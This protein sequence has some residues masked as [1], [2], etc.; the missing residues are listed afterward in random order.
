MKRRRV[1]GIY[2]KILSYTILIL[3][4]VIGV[5]AVF[6]ANQI[7]AI[8]E[9]MERQQL[10]NMISPLV[11]Q[12]EGKSGEEIAGIAEEFHAKNASAKFYVQAGNG[13]IIYK[14]EDAILPDSDNPSSGG[15]DVIWNTTLKGKFQAIEPLSNGT[16]IFMVSAS[17]GRAVYGEFIRRTIIV[18]LL[19]FIVGALCA[20]VFAYWFT[21]PI[22]NIARDTRRMSD[23]EFVPPPVARG[24]EIGQ[25]AKDVYQMY[26]DLKTEIE[27]EREMEENQRYF[28]SAASHELKTPIASTLILLQGML[29]N[30]GDYKD[31]PKYLREC[32]KKMKAQSKMISEILEIVRLQ[33]GRMIPNSETLELLPV[34]NAVV[35]S[36]QTLSEAREQSIEVSVPEDLTVK[37]DRNM[38]TRV[39]SNVLLNAIQN[40]PEQGRIRI[41]H[42]KREQHIRL[43][44]LNEDAGID[45]EALSKIFEPFYRQDKARSSGQGRSG[46]GLNIVKKTLDGMKIPFSLENSEGGV[47]F[48]MDLNI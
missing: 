7:T 45:K 25:L 24:D 6:F 17:P 46:L 39:L 26:E 41:W 11:S 21:K 20:A 48:W 27:R 18:L 32:I 30:I 13:E 22:K 8:L 44:V 34:V 2:G 16:R 4:V 12:L 1:F 5:A 28:F 43:Y 36:H 10:T 35:S 15:Q 37:A 42:E 29:D 40:T 33:D 9:S 14:T 23:L 31:H 3:L 19:L 38:L 47:L